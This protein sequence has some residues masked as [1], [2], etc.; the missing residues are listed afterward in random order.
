MQREQTHRTGH[1]P[2]SGTV[3]TVTLDLADVEDVPE[4][5]RVYLMVD[6]YPAAVNTLD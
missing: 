6:A 1:T 2:P 5:L 4:S 3:E